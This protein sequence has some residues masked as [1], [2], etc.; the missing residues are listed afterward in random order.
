[1]RIFEV[2][3]VL[4]THALVCALSSEGAYVARRHRI[5]V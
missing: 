3:R 2:P 5:G 4:R 1:M